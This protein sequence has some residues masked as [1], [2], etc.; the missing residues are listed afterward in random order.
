MNDKAH[1][2][3][4]QLINDIALVDTELA[5][6]IK[7][8]IDV[9]VESIEDNDL[10][11]K[12]EDYFALTDE[13]AKKAWIKDEK[14]KDVVQKMYELSKM[15]EAKQTPLN[16]VKE[17]KNGETKKDGP[18]KPDDYEETEIS[19]A[20]PEDGFKDE[21]ITFPLKID[22][23]DKKFFGK[24]EKDL[25]KEKDLDP[26]NTP[27]VVDGNEGQ[28]EEVKTPDPT[29][30]P[31]IIADE[32]VKKIVRKALRESMKKVLRKCKLMVESMKDEDKYTKFLDK[33]QADEQAAYKPIRWFATRLYREFEKDFASYSDA[34]QVAKTWYD[35]VGRAAHAATKPII[36]RVYVEMRK[37]IDDNFKVNVYLMKAIKSGDLS[38]E[39]ETLGA[40]IVNTFGTDEDP[41]W[42]NVGREFRSP[43]LG[44]SK[45]WKIQIDLPRNG[46]RNVVLSRIKHDIVNQIRA[47]YGEKYLPTTKMPGWLY[48]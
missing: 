13:E 42:K 9:F 39:D 2:A 35:Y 18:V 26:N 27:K 10:Y 22:G 12:L 30:R 24:T 44:P 1:S 47:N 36:P 28:A 11:K 3:A 38:E 15:A 23:D 29:K 48:V 31:G 46:K 14:N 4:L 20:L 40:D 6:K 43:E 32:S 45:C 34:M 17:M 16:E 5:A 37:D 21:K 19:G 25:P 7:P 8:S 41:E 33:L